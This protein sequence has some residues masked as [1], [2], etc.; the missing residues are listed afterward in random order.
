MVWYDPNLRNASST[1]LTLEK[2]VAELRRSMRTRLLALLPPSPASRKALAWVRVRVGVRARDRVRVRVRVT[3]RVTWWTV[4]MVRV[5]LP[6][7]TVGK[8]SL[9]CTPSPEVRPPQYLGGWGKRRVW[10]IFV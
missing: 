9:L 2:R 8:A 1:V 3:V 7:A 10:M 5:M 4:L 6:L